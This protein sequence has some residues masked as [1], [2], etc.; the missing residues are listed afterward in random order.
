MQATQKLVWACSAPGGDTERS[1]EARS[2]Q[3]SG[4]AETSLRRPA[5]MR[6][7][8]SDEGGQARQAGRLVWEAKGSDRLQRTRIGVGSEHWPAGQSAA[9]RGPRGEGRGWGHLD[10]AVRV[11]GVVRGHRYAEN[12]PRCL[13]ANKPANF[14]RT[15]TPVWHKQCE[16][17]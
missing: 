16:T 12:F 1:C 4:A 13:T 3:R 14:R 5:V 8:D 7:G 6:V 17:P 10:R 2:A 9:R 11:E 15:A